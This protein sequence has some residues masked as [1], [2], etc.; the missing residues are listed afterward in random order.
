MMAAAVVVVVLAVDPGGY[1]GH[2]LLRFRIGGH[3]PDRFSAGDIV[4][5]TP[6]YGTE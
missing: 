3:D 6:R 4:Y 1:Q 2:C 5:V